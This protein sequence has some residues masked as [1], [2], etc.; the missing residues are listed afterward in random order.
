[1]EA[2]HLRPTWIC[3]DRLEVVLDLIV[4]SCFEVVLAGLGIY[5]QV[6]LRTVHQLS[7]APKRNNQC[8]QERFSGGSCCV[9]AISACL[10]LR[11]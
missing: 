9:S 7:L 4:L 3:S 2:I 6:T 5:K 10:L 8:S 11:V 1:M